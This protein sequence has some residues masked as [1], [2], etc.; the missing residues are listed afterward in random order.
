MSMPIP[1]SLTV[2]TA[3]LSSVFSA[4]ILTILSPSVPPFS[5]ASVNLTALFSRL[6]IT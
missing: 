5:F 2:T 3:W 1:L 4:A 6:K